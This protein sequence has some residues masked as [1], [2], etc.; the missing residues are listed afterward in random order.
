MNRWF[1]PRRSIYHHL[2]QI[3][4]NIYEK[5]TYA[6]C[7]AWSFVFCY[8]FF[9]SSNLLYVIIGNQNFWL[10][11]IPSRFQFGIARFPEKHVIWTIPENRISDQINSMKII[12]VR[13]ISRWIWNPSS[14]INSEPTYYSCYAFL[15]SLLLGVCPPHSELEVSISVYDIFKIVMHVCEWVIQYDSQISYNKR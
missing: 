1:F 15:L 6:V 10:E 3:Y 4:F 12:E 14:S 2:L 7:C 11:N 9:F 13:Y 8:R 5:A